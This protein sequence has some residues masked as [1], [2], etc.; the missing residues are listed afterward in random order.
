LTGTA[1]G[2]AVGADARV[3]ARDPS[4]WKVVDTGLSTEKALHSVWVDESRGVWAVGGDVLV[5]P[6]GDG[7]LVHYGVPVAHSYRDIAV[8]LVHTRLDGGT[9][10]EAEAGPIF[11]AGAP[12]ASPHEGG[13]ADVEAAE[14]GSTVTVEA[15][16]LEAGPDARPPS[17]SGLAT[18]GASTCDLTV[19][20]CCVDRT[21]AV[22]PSCL[23]PGT[24]CPNNSYS[25][26]CDE[27]TDCSSGLVCC[28]QWFIQLNAVY[29]V[30]CVATCVDYVLCASDSECPVGSVCDWSTQVPGYKTCR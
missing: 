7:V 5:P 13:G 16:P 25:L 10:G 6:L 17:G 3:L 27:G 28:A 23:A 8:T 12:E 15:G 30:A 21:G 29:D 11:E 9:G 24:V 14:T 1:G 18:C 2:Y 22:E 26:T 19:A 4:G 20:Q